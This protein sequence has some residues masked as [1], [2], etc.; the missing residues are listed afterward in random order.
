MFFESYTTYGL[1]RPQSGF[2]W[3]TLIA[4]VS[5][6]NTWDDPWNSGSG[7]LFQTQVLGGNQ[8][9]FIVIRE[10]EITPLFIKIS[11]FLPS[12]TKLCG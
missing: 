9:G 3:A 12:K 4:I 11:I 5:T 6:W 1:F 2:T 8:Q 10:D 7:N